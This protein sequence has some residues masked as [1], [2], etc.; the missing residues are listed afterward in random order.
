MKA[1]MQN[2]PKLVG[3]P[4]VCRLLEISDR[5][6]EKMVAANL[7]PNPLRLG[8]RVAWSEEAVV[9]WLKMSL[10]GQLNREPRKRRFK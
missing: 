2:A 4:D 1:F 6:L 3:K 7:F 9:R 10:E 8:K 5:T